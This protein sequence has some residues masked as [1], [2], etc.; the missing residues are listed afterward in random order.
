MDAS[1]AIGKTNDYKMPK[2]AFPPA[3]D[4]FENSE[5]RMDSGYQ[6][7][8]KDYKCPNAYL[9][10]EAVRVTHKLRVIPAWASIRVIWK[11]FRLRN[12]VPRFR[13]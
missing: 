12:P 8:A 2:E 6:G 9:P 1:N 3:E 11:S 13:F 5:A 10:P 7:F 4:R